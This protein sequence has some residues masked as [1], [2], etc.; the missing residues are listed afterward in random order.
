LF[1]AKTDETYRQ[2]LLESEGFTV[3]RIDPNETRSVLR[4]ERFPLAVITTERGPQATLE[5]CREL[6]SQ[7]PTMH[8][9]VLAQ[10]AEYL[11]PDSCIDALVREQYSPGQFVAAVRRAMNGEKPAPEE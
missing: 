4:T 3:R 11:P 7:A 9:L 5:F 2:L 8:V 10:R 6:K 1:I